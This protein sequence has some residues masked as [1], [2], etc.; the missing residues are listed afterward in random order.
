[1][2]QSIAHPVRA[3]ERVCGHRRGGAR[4]GAARCSGPAGVEPGPRAAEHDLDDPLLSDP[5]GTIARSF[6]VQHPG[7]LPPRRQT[8]VLDA[9]LTLLGAFRSELHM[10]IHADEALALLRARHG[11]PPGTDIEHAAHPSAPTTAPRVP[12]LLR[13]GD[14]EH[15]MTAVG[16]VSPGAM[17]AAVGACLTRAGTTVRW[18]SAGR[19]EATRRRAEEADLDDVGTLDSLCDRAE[20]LLSVCPP[21]AAIATAEAV[22]ACGFTGVYVDANAI[23]PATA[24]RVAGIVGDRA[25]FVDGGIIGP[26]PREPG[27]TR[28]YLAGSAAPSVAALFAPEPLTAVVLG[29][30]VPSA[31]ALK[32]AYAAWT[33]GSSALL[34]TVRAFAA[35]E[36][37]EEDL[38][39]EWSRSIPDL[40]ERTE[41]VAARNAPKAWRW[42]G[43]MEEI[44]DALAVTGLPDGFHRGAAE[45]YRRLGH[46]KDTDGATIA[47]VVTD[48]LDDPAG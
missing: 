21:H 16:I 18:S 1:M 26:P 40:P 9:D 45:I 31:S 23:A 33:K 36:G 7:P 42:V 8:F 28:L 11:W 32:V 3:P 24:Q 27:T 20:V 22:A 15:R 12:M 47:D 41:A 35:V 14:E 2:V 38:L 39:A 5:D 37:V 34:L 25:R 17:G 10:D 4:N 44:A 30:D 46:R 6:G 43:E 48:L 19:S 13:V 29:G